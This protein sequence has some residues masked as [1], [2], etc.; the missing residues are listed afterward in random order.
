M[1]ST[2]TTVA[3]SK[4]EST[5]RFVDI[6]SSAI[7]TTRQVSNPNEK[8]PLILDEEFFR[9]PELHKFLDLV[10]KYEPLIH[11]EEFIDTLRVS[12]YI[13]RRCPCCTHYLCQVC[14]TRIIYHRD[15]LLMPYCHTCEMFLDNRDSK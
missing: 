6:P 4:S 13:H 12:R 3:L 9:L 11:R 14:N 8:V 10:H 1:A 15:D 7:W 2:S 5:S